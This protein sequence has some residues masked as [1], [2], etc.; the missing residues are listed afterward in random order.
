MFFQNT[1]EGEDILWMKQMA[2]VFGK[3]FDADDIVRVLT[4]EREDIDERFP[5]QEVSTGLPFIIV[6]LRTLDAVKRARIN[7]DEPLKLI[8]DTQAK[9]F[10]IF[11]PQ[12]YERDRD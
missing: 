9:M 10:L 11:C 6:P 12:T 1:R 7:K 2:P 8:E 4:I 5:V 3:V